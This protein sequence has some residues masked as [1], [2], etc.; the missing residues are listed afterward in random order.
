MKTLRL[1]KQ[2]LLLVIVWMLC[3]IAAPIFLV[4]VGAKYA[5]DY[6]DKR[7]NKLDTLDIQEYIPYVPATTDNNIHSAN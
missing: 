6:L 5:Q 7:Q 3:V 1:I 2:I 4:I